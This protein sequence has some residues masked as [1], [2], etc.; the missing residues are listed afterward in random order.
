MKRLLLLLTL[1]PGM[2]SAKSADL[3]ITP[4]PREIILASGSF[5]LRGAGF[6]YSSALEERSVKVIAALADDVSAATGK[7]SSLAIA[8]GVKADSEA[9]RLKGIYFLEDKAVP[10]E[11]YRIEVCRKGIKITASDHNGFFYAVQTLRQML[12]V[13]VY[14]GQADGSMR[15]PCCTISDGPR[16]GYRGMMLDACRH[17]WSI[18]ETKKFIDIMAVYKLNRLHWHLT[19]DQGWRIEIKRY[20]ELTETGA[21]RSGTQVGYDREKSDGVRYGGYYTQEQ[22]KEV[23]AYAWERGITVVP[24]VDLPG[25]MLGALAS[26]PQLGC[27]GGPYEVWYHWGVSKDVLCVGKDETFSFLEGVMDELCEIFPSEYIHIGGDECPKDRWKECPLCQAR[28][29]ALGLVSD[30]TGSR[31]DKLQNYVTSRMQKYLGEKGR[32]IIGWDEILQGQLEPGATVMSWRGTRGGIEAA[33]RGFDVIMTPTDYMYFDY[34]Q[35]PAEEEPDGPRWITDPL[36]LSD[37]YSFDPYA[38]IPAESQKHILGV[39]A[40]LW[41]EYIAEPSHLEYMLLPRMLATAEVQWCPSEERSFERFHSA[42]V[43]HQ[44]KVL[45][46]LGYNFRKEK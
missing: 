29:D 11:N 46:V 10:A 37:V 16:F 22:L 38:G 44:E 20:P 18:E 32:K 14:K 9:S 13:G 35:G 17:F 8:A 31:E 30:E 12:P 23:V 24:E 39:Q 28:A 3:Q 34:R 6:N 27:T 5:N 36:T 15:V 26:Y 40:N 33:K 1:I 19:E 7:V 42:L 4:Q 2:L 43:G 25:H 41:T 21:F 45:E